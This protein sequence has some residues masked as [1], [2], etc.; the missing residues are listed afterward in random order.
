MAQTLAQPNYLFLHDMYKMPENEVRNIHNE[1]ELI[2]FIRKRFKA[3]YAKNFIAYS[4][5]SL[6]TWSS[7][8]PVSKRTLQRELEKSK[9]NFDIKISEPLIEIGEIYSLGLQAFDDDK[10]RLNE[11]LKAENAY[12][13]GHKPID[14]MDTH[15]GRDLIKSELL[16]IEYSEF[17]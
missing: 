17:S 16:R 14:I 7:I 9:Y 12:F 3:S 15:K 1:A 2:D 10:K 11:W 4:E 6:S 5:L 13:N 8:L